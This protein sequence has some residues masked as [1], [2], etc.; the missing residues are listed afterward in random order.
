MC[1]F[2]LFFRRAHDARR[3]SIDSTIATVD[4]LAEKKH[5]AERNLPSARARRIDGPLPPEYTLLLLPTRIGRRQIEFT[6]NERGMLRSK[7]RVGRARH[8]RGVFSRIAFLPEQVIGEIR[9]RVVDDAEYGSSYAMDLGETLTLEPRAPFRYLNH[10]CSPN[11]E[12]VM[13]DADGDP[14]LARRMFLQAIAPIEP[15]DEL[16]IDYGWPAETAIP[17]DC[18]S[19][20]CRGWIVDLAEL[21]LLPEP[22]E[23]TI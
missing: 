3:P 19:M 10:C 16:T 20:N 6:R 12:L 13:Y 9:G 18:D 11:C 15:G 23:L 4:S 1:S 17:C 5:S 8:G 22:L 21:H 14:S 2:L 7:V